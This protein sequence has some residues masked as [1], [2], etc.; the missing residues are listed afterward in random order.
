MTATFVCLAEMKREMSPASKH[1]GDRV[2]CWDNNA[3]KKEHT[4]GDS[5]GWY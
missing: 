2:S 4:V 3:R 5:G 1:S